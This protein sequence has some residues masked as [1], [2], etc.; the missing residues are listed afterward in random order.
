[1]KTCGQWTAVL[2]EVVYRSRASMRLPPIW[3]KLSASE[4]SRAMSL[5]AAQYATLDRLHGETKAPGRLI[6]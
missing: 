3:K 2:L 1:M 4:T 6:C 5:T